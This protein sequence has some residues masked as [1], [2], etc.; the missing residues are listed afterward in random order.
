M[1]SQAFFGADSSIHAQLMRHFDR[2]A[3]DVHVACTTEAPWRADA[4]AA[5]AISA[6]PDVAVRPTY[7]GP[8]VHG[9]GAGDRLRRLSQA[10][11][12]ALSLLGLAAYIRR[13]HIR[14][15]HCTEKPRDALY[16][17]LL[18]K[19]AGA[20]SVIHMHVAYEGWLS[21]TVKWALREADGV[22]AISD[23]VADS[24]VRG[25][26]P[27]EKIAVVHNSLDLQGWDP[28]LDGDA[29]RRELGLP[30]GAP[31]VGIISRLFRWKGHS[32][33]LE[34]VAEVVRDLPDLRLVI[35]GE[36]DPRAVPGEGSYRAE[37]EEQ[38]G[39]LR[40]E[41][42]VVFTG[43]RTDVPRLMSA[44]DV[45]AHPSWEEPFGMVFLEAMAMRKPVIA[46]ASGGGPEVVTSGE[47]GLLVE[48]G[49][50]PA[51]ADALRSVLTDDALRGRL[52]D[53]GRRQV[54]LVFTPE[55]MCA[56]ALRAYQGVLSGC[57]PDRCARPGRAEPDASEAPA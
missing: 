4:S 35:V 47:T 48:R 32:Y 13:H 22:I 11:R 25:G 21:K 6:L 54:E 12:L 8:S 23:F 16:G 7:F 24:L 51:L 40:I 38:A 39:R 18:G 45:F 52:G 1:Q 2:S 20:K 31:V 57:R 43:F 14:I 17:V 42:N 26:Y 37:L 10:P 56:G 19:L 27:R 33:L 34:A 46:W 49:S 53:A 29:A 36:D 9:V 55:R 5:H 44:F 3:V 28:A 15:I 41:R 30:I 50:V